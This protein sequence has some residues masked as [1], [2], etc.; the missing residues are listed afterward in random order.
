MSRDFADLLKVLAATVLVFAA[1]TLVLLYGV[2]VL[3]QYGGNLPLVGSLS[4]N[5]PPSIVPML[6]D[7]R[8][9]ITLAA[10]HVTATGLALLINSNTIDMALLITSKAVA[11]VITALLGCVGGQMVY[12]QLTEKT[13]FVLA[14]L[15]PA[16]VALVGF[17]I[18]STIL[19]AYNLRQTGNLRFVIALGL[20]VLGPVLLLWL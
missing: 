12:L 17:L 18:L 2:Y 10:A 11:V 1:G 3:V 8:L 19:A 14:P 6:V 9:F 15:T 5:A 4:R 13:A 16:F 20:I 7:N